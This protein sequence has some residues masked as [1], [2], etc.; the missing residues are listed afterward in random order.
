MT[1]KIFFQIT[2][3]WALPTIFKATFHRR[4]RLMRRLALVD[5]F[6]KFLLCILCQQC[7][8][9]DCSLVCITKLKEFQNIS[10]TI[11]NSYVIGGNGGEH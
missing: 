2:E 10:C 6:P 3:K 7:L 11:P 5:H 8:G 1:C 4:A 9:N